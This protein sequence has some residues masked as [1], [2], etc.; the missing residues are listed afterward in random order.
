MT[1]PKH[2]HCTYIL[3]QKDYCNVSCPRRH[4]LKHGSHL[5]A[6]HCILGQQKQAFP[7]RLEKLFDQL[8][9]VSP[10]RLDEVSPWLQTGMVGEKW[11]RKKSFIYCKFPNSRIS[12]AKGC[13]MKKKLCSQ[14]LSFVNKLRN[15][16]RDDALCTIILNDPMSTSKDIRW[17]FLVRKINYFPFRKT[18]KDCEIL[19]LAHI[20]QA[21]KLHPLQTICTG[22]IEG[23][24]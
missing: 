22:N 7:Q 19:N 12:E 10:C 15:V 20:I 9:E 4:L 5:N 21:F 8:D 2:V 1:I 16:Y 17:I 6:S 23:L 14:R 18:L 24:G 13:K 3:W 11:R